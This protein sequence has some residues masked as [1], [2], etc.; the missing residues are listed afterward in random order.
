MKVDEAH[1]ILNESFADAMATL[2]SGGLEMV[3]AWQYGDQIQDE[4][5]RGGMMSLLRQRC[6]FSMGESNDARELS[7]IA[8]SVLHGHD[9]QR[10]RVSRAAADHAG[11]DLQPAQPPCRLL[12]DQPRSACPGVHRQTLPLESDEE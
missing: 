3:A 9:P 2:R 11:H 5:V 4:K 8:M 10:R 1:L 6:M 12:V 7:Q